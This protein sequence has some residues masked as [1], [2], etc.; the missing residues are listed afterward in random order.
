MSRAREGT[1]SGGSRRTVIRAPNHLGDLVMSL[2]ALAAAPAA[3]IL[4][5][6]WLEPLLALALPGRTAIP[7]DRGARGFLRGV[8]ALRA[9]RY[10]RGIILPPSFS[11]ALLFRAGRVRERRGIDAHS[12]APLLTDILDRRMYAGVHRA[13]RFL[14]LVTGDRSPA[15]SPP[16]PGVAIPAAL[17]ERWLALAGDTARAT[18]GLFP[19][20]NAA[21]RRWDAERFADVA[22]ALVARGE[23]VIVFGGPHERN[24]TA[25]V[26]G[27][28]AVDMGGRTDLPLLA[29]ALSEC[30]L[31]VTN[32]SG[33]LH[34]AAAV[35]TPTVSLWG[36]GDPA[37]TGP[38]GEGHLL[39]RHPEL[40]CV[41][42]VR[43]TCPR[44]GRGYILDSASRECVRLFTA[45]EVT[46]RALAHRSATPLA[47]RY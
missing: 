1:R 31:L 28:V 21:S 12:R 24:L 39:L 7:L 20:S 29:A 11:S 37:V 13:A 16:V 18:I 25:A 47:R 2:P 26:A 42:C 40:P 36:A 9:R 23:R 43:N 38:L 10:D 5:A 4:I 3:D 41:P 32:D 46:A 19:G 15:G 44:H 17:R 33:P 6:R 8:R 45:A 34:L 30:A 22:H 14:T 27:S 35:G